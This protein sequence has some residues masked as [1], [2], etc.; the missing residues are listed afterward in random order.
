MGR[1]LPLLIAVL[2][3]AGCED[4]DGKDRSIGAIVI[5]QVIFSAKPPDFAPAAS[6]NA[7][8]LAWQSDAPLVGES[9]FVQFAPGVEALALDADAATIVQLS[10]T[11][12]EFQLTLYD[13]RGVLV[14]WGGGA[15]EQSLSAAAGRYFVAIFRVSGDGCLHLRCD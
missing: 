6:D 10:A 9:G 2:A 15:A 4:E 3:L 5:R 1:Y 14:A 11:G 8:V 12:G 7:A 13:D